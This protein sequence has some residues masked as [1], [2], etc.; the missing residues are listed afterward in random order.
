MA[1]GMQKVKIAF[2]ENA[3][4]YFLSDDWSVIRAGLEVG[5]YTVVMTNFNLQGLGLPNRSE[6]RYAFAILEKHAQLVEN[7][8]SQVQHEIKQ[9]GERKKQ[10]HQCYVESSE[11][12]KLYKLDSIHVGVFQVLGTT[13]Q[14]DVENALATARP[15]CPNIETGDYVLDLSRPRKRTTS[16][17]SEGLCPCI[18]TTNAWLRLY[19]TKQRRFLYPHELMHIMGFEQAVHRDF[20]MVQEL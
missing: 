15:N 13:L 11:E 6:R 19:S 16:Q 3:A 5:G 7:W 12:L 2:F 20:C 14:D 1:L 4:R 9:E 17:P 18:T 8:C 10:L